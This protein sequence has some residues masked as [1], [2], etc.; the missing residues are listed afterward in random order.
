MIHANYIIFDIFSG[1]TLTLLQIYYYKIK[2]IIDPGILKGATLCIL[3][4]KKSKKMIAG[5]N[6]TGG[7]ILA[8][9]V[10][11]QKCLILI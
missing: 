5:L 11:C 10:K 4:S 6:L 8:P 1:Q 3:Y 2:N 7:M 9:P